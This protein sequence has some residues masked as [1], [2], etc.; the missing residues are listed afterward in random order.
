MKPMSLKGGM[1]KRWMDSQKVLG[2]VIPDLIRDPETYENTG[3]RVKPGMTLETVF[4][5][6]TIPL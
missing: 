1:I 3:F 2:R 6:F 4:G 5:L